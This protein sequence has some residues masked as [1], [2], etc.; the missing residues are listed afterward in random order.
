MQIIRT[1]EK[2]DEEKEK[3]EKKDAKK[4]KAGGD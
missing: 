1:M 4:R 3:K 2:G